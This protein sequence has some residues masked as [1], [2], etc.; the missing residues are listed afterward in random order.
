MKAK[1][2]MILVGVALLGLVTAVAQPPQMQQAKAELSTG[3]GAIT[4]SYGQPPLG[5]RDRV[6]EQKVGDFWRMGKNQ[7][8]VIT[9]PLD[10]NFAGVTVPK[11]SYSL[12]LLREAPDK[13]TLVFNAQTGQWGTQHDPSKDLYKVPLRHEKTPDSVELFTIDLKK[14]ATGG[15]LSLTWGTSRLTADFQFAR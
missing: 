8:T 5:G 10:L 1:N 13:Y 15:Q 6:A 3:S 14:A 11:G 12:F 4:I 2:I 7:A 9:N